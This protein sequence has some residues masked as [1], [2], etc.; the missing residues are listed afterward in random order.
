MTPTKKI[1]ALAVLLAAVPLA[2]ASF[3]SDRGHEGRPGH[4]A[5]QYGRGYDRGHHYGHDRHRHWH[6]GHPGHRHWHG[7]NGYHQY[8]SGYRPGIVLPLPPPPLI[9]LDRHL[10]GH[11]VLHPGR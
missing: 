8:D 3:A 2:P 4:H 10:R 9:V 7:G 6:H 1:A 11:I 5:P